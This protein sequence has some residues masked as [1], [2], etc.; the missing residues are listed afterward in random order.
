MSEFLNGFISIKGTAAVLAGTFL[1]C[2]IGYALGRITI[3]GISLGDSGVF[4]IALLFGWLFTLPVLQE[5]PVLCQ[6]Y[7]PNSGT[8]MASSYKFIQNVGLVLFVT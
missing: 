2:F 4:I 6:F 3:K 5:I 1:I 7:I 8:S